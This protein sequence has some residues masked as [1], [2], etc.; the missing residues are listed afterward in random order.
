MSRS[1]VSV[2]NMSGA[3]VPVTKPPPTTRASPLRSGAVAPIRTDGIRSFNKGCPSAWFMRSVDRAAPPALTAVV[4]AMPAAMAAGV[5]TAA[6]TGESV[7]E[8]SPAAHPTRPPITAPSKPPRF[9]PLAAPVIYPVA[10]PVTAAGFKKSQVLYNLARTLEE[11]STGAV[12]LVEG[13]FD[14]MK[15]VQAEHVCVALMGCSLSGD[16]EEQLVVH[17]RQV[18]IML[19]GDEAGR[20]ATTDIAGC[21]AHRLWVR[22]VDL[23]DGKQ[24]DQLAIGELQQ[25]LKT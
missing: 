15:V 23:P 24:P 16:Q 2:A 5:A 20:R 18:V 19:D 1:P 14:C 10:A 3:S 21:L 25:L 11:D 4:I 22:V 9:P 7:A 8:M 13:F 6:A 12:V 17:F